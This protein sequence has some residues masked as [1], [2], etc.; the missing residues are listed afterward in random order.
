MEW[1]Y[2]VVVIKNHYCMNNKRQKIKRKI[3]QKE[4]IK[5][6]AGLCYSRM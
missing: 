5:E 1:N 2:R 4:A 3:P 6:I